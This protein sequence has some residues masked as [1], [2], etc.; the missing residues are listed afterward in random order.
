MGIPQECGVNAREIEE[1]RVRRAN[2]STNDRAVCP[3][4][5]GQAD[6]QGIPQSCARERRNIKT[7]QRGIRGTPLAGASG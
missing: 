1:S 3:P 6:F 7:R 5:S 4:P 2:C